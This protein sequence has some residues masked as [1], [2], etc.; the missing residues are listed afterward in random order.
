MESKGFPAESASSYKVLFGYKIMQRECAV[1]LLSN[2]GS[3]L[4]LSTFKGIKVRT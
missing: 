2:E 1:S 4:Q 3:W